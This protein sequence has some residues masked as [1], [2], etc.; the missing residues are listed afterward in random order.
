MFNYGQNHQEG[1]SNSQQSSSTFN[2]RQEQQLQNQRLIR[3][4]S[5]TKAKYPFQNPEANAS[6]TQVSSIQQHQ[7]QHQQPQ[8]QQPQHKHQQH[9]QQQQMQLTTS[10]LRRH[11]QLNSRNPVSSSSASSQY[12]Q[13]TSKVPTMVSNPLAAFKARKDRERKRV[14]DSYDIVGY[15]AAGTYGKYVT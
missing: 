7:R 5:L 3:S 9:Q 14:L 12:Y 15:I 10:T 11:D 13:S 8:H 2:S 6:S 1:R 4:Q